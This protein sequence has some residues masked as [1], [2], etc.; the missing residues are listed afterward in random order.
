MSE[1]EISDSPATIFRIDDDQPN[2]RPRKKFS[3]PRIKADNAI[4]IARYI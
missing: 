1:Q 3:I 4:A 2:E